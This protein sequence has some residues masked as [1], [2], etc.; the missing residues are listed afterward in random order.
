MSFVTL[1]Y[2][3]E[4]VRRNQMPFGRDTRV[5]QSNTVLCRAPVP[6]GEIWGSELPVRSDAAYRQ[7]TLTLVQLVAIQKDNLI[8][9]F[10]TWR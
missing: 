10:W 4:A 3:A 8:Q 1:M 5:V 2:S 6:H 9:V 7:I